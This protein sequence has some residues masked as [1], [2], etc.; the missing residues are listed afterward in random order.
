[1][2]AK[3]KPIYLSLAIALL[4]AGCSNAGGPQMLAAFP[5]ATPIAVYPGQVFIVYN[6][7]IELTV[8]NVDPAAERAAQMAYDN[9]GYLSGSQSW[10]VDGRKNTTLTLAVPTPN[11]DRLRR[12]LLSLGNL[13]SESLSGESTTP[14]YNE[15]QYSSITLHLRPGGL[16]LLPID[17]PG[18]DPGRTFQQ[19]FAVFLSIFGFLA[20]IAIWLVVVGGPFILIGWLAWRLIRRLRRPPTTDGK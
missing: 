7:Y 11:F 1:M 17:A 16:A 18:W 4:L 12:D 13:V 2:F 14:R 10:Y 6:A 5:R 19:A 15:P 20:D 9:G 8:S 3:L